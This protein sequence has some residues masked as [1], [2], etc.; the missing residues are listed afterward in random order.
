MTNEKKQIISFLKE[1]KSTF[2]DPLYT[3]IIGAVTKLAH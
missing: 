2:S 3:T 1:E